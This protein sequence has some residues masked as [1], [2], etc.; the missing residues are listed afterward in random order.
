MKGVNSDNKLIRLKNLMT[1]KL[2]KKCKK[3]YYDKIS[4]VNNMHLVFSCLTEKEPQYVEDKF[5][6]ANE[7]KF[8]LEEVTGYLN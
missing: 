4:P 6:Y 2:P 7:N 3:N 8:V 1:F 5:F